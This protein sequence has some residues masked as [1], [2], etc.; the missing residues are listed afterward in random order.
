MILVL[1]MVELEILLAW[2]VVAMM[3]LLLPAGPHSSPLEGLGVDDGDDTPGDDDPA[4][5]GCDVF[6]SS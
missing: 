3:L 5:Y 2:L 1:A 6:D 4:D